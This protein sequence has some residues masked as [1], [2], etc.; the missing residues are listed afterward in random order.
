MTTLTSSVLNAVMGS[1]A[2]Y[3]K[4]KNIKI[5]GRDK[6]DVVGEAQEIVY[7]YFNYWGISNIPEGW[8]DDGDN[9]LCYQL[10]H[11]DYELITSVVKE[12]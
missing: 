5:S 2:L 11:A 9:E 4:I 7:D 1:T 8:R 10:E 6:A 12:G 3:N